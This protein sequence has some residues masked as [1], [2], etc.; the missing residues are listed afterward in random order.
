MPQA[1]RLFLLSI[2]DLI[3]SAGP[4]IFLVIGLLVAAYWWLQPQPPKQ[5]TLATGPAGSANAEFGKRYA[6]ALK[7]DGIEVVL[8]PTDGSLDNLQLLRNGGADV[9]FVRGGSADPVK[10]EEAGLTSLGSLFFEPLWFFYRTDAARKIDRKTATLTSLTQLKGLRINVD[11]PGSGVP[12]IMDRMFRANHMDSATLELSNLEQT[13]ATEA[14]QAGLLD[15]IVLASAPQSPLVQR[16][17]RAPDIQL[18][19]FAQS[20]AYSRRFAFLQPVTLPRGVVDLASDLPSQDVS[21]L[22]ATTSLLAREETHPALRQLFAQSAQTLH[23][24]AGWFNRAR[25]F[26]NTRTS[27]LPVSPEGDRAIN[28]TPPFWQRYLPFWASNLVERMWLVLGGL[29]VL[30]LPLSRVVPPL[31]QFRVRRRVF[32]WYARLRDVESRLE[33]GKGTTEALLK[34]LDDLDRVVNKV[35]V[36]LSYADELY[37]LRNNIYAVRKRILARSPQDDEGTSLAVAPRS[38]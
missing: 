26:P 37:A 30:M 22:A 12:D 27:E 9:A 38:A 10:D 17:L 35:A 1:I 23:G 3:A 28:G 19:D 25:D 24:G 20:D 16:L 2:R 11:K 33:S 32:R 31:Y 18:M 15:V 13:P 7:T 21:L 36:P 6:A 29:L 8:K 4:V 14:L 34:E 5:V